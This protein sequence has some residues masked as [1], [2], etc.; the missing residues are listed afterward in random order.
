MDGVAFEDGFLIL[1]MIECTEESC[2]ELI[3]FGHISRMQ[4]HM[5]DRYIND[6][7]IY[8]ICK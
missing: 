4:Y 5:I 8:Y 6:T 2:C 3:L 7:L 1:H